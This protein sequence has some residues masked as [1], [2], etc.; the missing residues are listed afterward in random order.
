M[1]G[2]VTPSGAGRAGAD[3]PFGSNPKRP[4]P[5]LSYW[6]GWRAGF[7]LFAFAEFN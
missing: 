7:D 5:E 6:F 1:P 3:V 4:P 2:C